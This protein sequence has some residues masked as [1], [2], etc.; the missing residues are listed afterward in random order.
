[1]LSI[2]EKN[3]IHTF[4]LTFW[5]GKS[6]YLHVMCADGKKHRPDF[7]WELL[8]VGHVQYKCFQIIH[9]ITFTSNQSEI[10]EN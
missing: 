7:E 5:F 10:N 6:A 3:E 9:P 8:E 2:E 4:L 1:M